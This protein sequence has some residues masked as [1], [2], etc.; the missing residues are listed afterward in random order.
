MLFR[1]RFNVI[2]DGEVIEQLTP[3]KRHYSARNSIMTEAAIDVTL[4]RDIYV[5][6]GE[7]LENG[8]WGMR[9]QVKPFMRWTWLGA[10]FMALGGFLAMLDKR[11]RRRVGVA[12][13]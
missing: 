2:Q 10:I 3:E 4:F 12:Q 5:S 6:M 1:S 9:L 11:Y 8:A 7:P 13:A